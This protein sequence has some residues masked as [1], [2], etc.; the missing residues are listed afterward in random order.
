MIKHTLIHFKFMK[1]NG[2]KES[3]MDGAE[4]FCP[5][6]IATLVNS[7][8]AKEK[9]SEFMSGMTVINI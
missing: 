9:D 3:F 8:K 1:A 7:T 5:K 6:A 2:V 4:Y